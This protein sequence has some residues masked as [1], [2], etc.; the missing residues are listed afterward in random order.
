MNYDK[1]FIIH[2]TQHFCFQYSLILTKRQLFGMRRGQNSK[3]CKFL[4]NKTPKMKLGQSVSSILELSE[5]LIFTA[6]RVLP[7]SEIWHQNDA[8]NK[9]PNSF[10]NLLRRLLIFPYELFSIIFGLSNHQIVKEQ[11]LISTSSIEQK[12]QGTLP[13]IKIWKLR[14]ENSFT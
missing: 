9:M 13:I 4:K 10:K 12:L 14:G 11:S 1:V 6:S 3:Y 7:H 5:W 2:Y 8:P